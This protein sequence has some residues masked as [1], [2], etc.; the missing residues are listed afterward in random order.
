M[1]A[2]VSIT[3]LAKLRRDLRQVG[4]DLGDLKDANARA[5]QVVLSRADPPRRS[6]SLASSGRVSRSA[7]RVSILWGGARLPYA[8]PIH[9]GW[10]ARGIEPQPFAVDAAQASEA[11][12]LPLYL[13]DLDRIAGSLD[14][15]TY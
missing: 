3:G 15:R 9:W 8:G 5:G 10:A 2:Q 12:W 6:G 7:A 14:G 13:A 11:T 4:D 1:D